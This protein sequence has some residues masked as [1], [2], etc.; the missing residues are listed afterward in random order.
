M[1]EEQ[2]VNELQDENECEVL[3]PKA[4]PFYPKQVKCYCCGQYGHMKR[5]CK[6]AHKMCPKCGKVG[7]TESECWKVKPKACFVVEVTVI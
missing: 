7:H 2:K 4:E 6:F 1:M 3:S 5:E